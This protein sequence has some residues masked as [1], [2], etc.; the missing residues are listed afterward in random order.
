MIRFRS[1]VLLSLALA[2]CGRKDGP[3]APVKDP[4][5]VGK[6][7]GTVATTGGAATLT[8]PAG[9]LTSDV[10]ITVATKP[11]PRGDTRSVGGTAYEFGP[12]GTKFATPV[13]LTLKYDK[14][15]LPP[16]RAAREMRVAQL[17]DSGW[18]P[19]ETGLQIDSVSGA[20]KLAVTQLG[21]APEHGAALR[22]SGNLALSG[23]TPVA[24]HSWSWR[25]SYT[26]YFPPINPCAPILLSPQQ[27]FTGAIDDADCV[28]ANNNG[29][30]SDYFTVS[31][32]EQTILS[33]NISGA[34]T[35]PFGIQGRGLSAL[36]SASVGATL[37]T[38]VPPGSYSVFLSGIDSLARGAYT[39]TT[40]T[41]AVGSRSGCENL[42]VVAG[43][44]FTGT[45]TTTDCTA[46]VPQ[47]SPLVAF[48]GLPFQYD[49]YRV[50]LYGG[51]SYTIS[52]THNTPNSNGCLVLW[53]NNQIVAS[54]L[55]QGSGTNPKSV[56][57]TPSADL[58]YSIEVESCSTNGT[59][60][61][62]V[63]PMNYTVN[64]TGH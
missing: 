54:V 29:R 11:D 49:L 59:V 41:A 20:V 53:Q 30:R 44:S 48:R 10:K 2:A 4:N 23:S 12:E 8:I 22:A 45:V 14:T 3:S 19:L 9:A 55:D 61:N 39:V 35:G 43:Q 58:Y 40:S 63:L 17:T 57:V 34:V 28:V 60:W 32:S 64:I 36:S 52:L 25:P 38:L 46:T 62:A 26:P 56:T 42:P 50:R 7:G 16:G 31:V 13:T 1:L 18:V 6:T 51:K 21:G 27:S 15:K 33:L 47:N 5:V 37:V 24:F